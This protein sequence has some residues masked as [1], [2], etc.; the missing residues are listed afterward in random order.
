MSNKPTFEE[1]IVS[2]LQ[3]TL[4]KESFDSL[5]DRSK[6]IGASDVGGCPYKTIKSKLEKPEVSF[7]QS[8]I[9]QRGHIAEDL[10]AKMLTGQK[11]DRQVELKGDLD[12]F[13]LIAH[14]DF[15]IRGKNRSVVIEAKTVS[16]TV[17]E[18]YEAW[19]LQVQFQM[20]LLYQ[21]VDEDHK[22]EAYVVAI[23]VN[24]GWHKVFK[25]EFNDEL[26]MMA[27]NKASHLIEC[28]TQG[29]EPKAVIQNYCG[30]CPFIME[31]PKQGKFAKEMPEDIKK[32]LIDIKQH[33]LEVKENKKKETKVKEFLI[34][35]GLEKV[36]LDE[37]GINPEVMV[38]LKEISSNRFDTKRF[39]VEHP[40][41][42]DDFMNESSSHKLTIS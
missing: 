38:S 39:K 27:I 42:A 6:Y 14:L 2:N 8:I 32:D 19:I 13:P 25:I 29:A 24:T 36:K 41:L 12:E 33:K 21:D 34:N 11:Y 5:G 40:G 35:S 22:I 17:D 30:T 15:L 9:F 28:L 31:C 3:E 18:P 10:V 26:F 7:E 4:K 16:S 20:G 23:D 37:D 1:F